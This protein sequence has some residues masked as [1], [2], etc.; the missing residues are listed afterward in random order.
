MTQPKDS[1]AA[2]VTKKLRCTEY[3]KKFREPKWETFSKCYE[4]SLRY[5]LTRRVMEH[6]HKPWVWNGWDRVSDSSG[7]ST[8]RPSR[9]EIAPLS[10]V[11]QMHSEVRGRDRLSKFEPPPEPKPPFRGVDAEVK[12]R[13]TDTSLAGSRPGVRAR[14]GPTKE[15]LSSTGPSETTETD[16]GPL[17][18]SDQEPTRPGPRR[19]PRRPPAALHHGGSGDES[20]AVRKPSRAKSQPSLVAKETL[21]RSGRHH[22]LDAK[23]QVQGRVTADACVQTTRR[24]SDKR[25]SNPERRRARSADLEK[26]QRS[27]LTVVD[28]HWV[29]EYMRCFSARLR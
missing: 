23:Q 13:E 6:S 24:S 17:D 1:M 7:G 29:T 14:R 25:A 12:A 5:R 8:P 22:W 9:R 20:G 11:P 4:D 3:M 2:V 15:A 21:Q 26:T 27:E 10:V 28:S 19:R 16:A 18:S